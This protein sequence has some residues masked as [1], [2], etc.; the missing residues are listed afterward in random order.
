M[1]NMKEKERGRGIGGTVKFRPDSLRRILTGKKG[2]RSIR[3]KLGGKENDLR[4]QGRGSVGRGETC[5]AMGEL[6]V[7]P[8]G[9]FLGHCQA[10][11]HCGGAFVEVAETKTKWVGGGRCS[12]G[13][14]N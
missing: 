9:R 4:G 5:N 2:M 10:L 12:V 14:R 1:H 8:R 7:R 3:G 6:K 11:R 13:Y